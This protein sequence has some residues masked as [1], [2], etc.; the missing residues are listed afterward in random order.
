M[1]WNHLSVD[2][3]FMIMAPAAAMGKAPPP[4]A[5]IVLPVATTVALASSADGSPKILRYLMGY[6]I[7]MIIVVSCIFA[8][9]KVPWN[10]SECGLDRISPAT[11]SLVLRS[12][13]GVRAASMSRSNRMPTPP[14]LKSKRAIGR[15]S[16]LVK[17]EQCKELHAAA[18]LVASRTLGE[19]EVDV[20]G[21]DLIV[22]ISCTITCTTLDTL[23]NFGTGVV[24][25]RKYD[26]NEY[27]GP[28][29]K[30][31]SQGEVW[32]SQNRAKNRGN[33]TMALS[34]SANATAPSV[35]HK[36]MVS[37]GSVFRVADPRIGSDPDP[38]SGTRPFWGDN[39]DHITFHSGLSR[40]QYPEIIA[41]P[42]GGGK[43]LRCIMQISNSGVKS[44]GLWTPRETLTEYRQLVVK[45]RWIREH[46][47]GG[48]E[49]SQGGE[50]GLID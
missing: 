10:G 32:T 34:P 49:A 40:R 39:L 42:I 22:C 43:I 29:V 44:N 23:D 4:S 36:S 25:N 27:N 46:D 19:E 3:T 6:V 26:L 1:I 13:H 45:T 33:P 24:L 15:I 28:P 17:A 48:I 11:V 41:D 18:I 5:S 14:S 9:V 21:Y 37:C 30:L 16:E 38:S 35:W 7:G 12:I 31:D 47:E 50:L 2:T 8:S 20:F